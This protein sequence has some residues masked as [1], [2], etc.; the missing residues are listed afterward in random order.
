MP[1]YRGFG[2]L[3]SQ[4]PVGRL[5]MTAHS[6]CIY[7]PATIYVRLYKYGYGDKLFLYPYIYGTYVYGM[8]ILIRF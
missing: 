4:K 2:I 3:K 6:D 8:Y 7:T 5:L 1:G